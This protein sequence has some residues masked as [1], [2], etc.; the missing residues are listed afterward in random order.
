MGEARL[1]LPNGLMFT[2]DQDPEEE[3]GDEYDAANI[4]LEIIEGDGYIVSLNLRLDDVDGE[5]SFSISA[6]KVYLGEK[7]PKEVARDEFRLVL[8]KL[9]QAK[10]PDG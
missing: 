3:F 2:H 6:T 5:Y 9:K 10:E 7:G 4:T 1:R 8:D